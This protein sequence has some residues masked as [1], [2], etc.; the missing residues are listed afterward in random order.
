MKQE[1]IK[2]KEVSPPA[3]LDG[4]ADSADFKQ[5]AK[6]V[7][8]L[9]REATREEADIIFEGSP[10]YVASK[11]PYIHGFY[12]GEGNTLFLETN[13]ALDPKAKNDAS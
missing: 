5:G 8:F 6:E 13:P 1:F 3:I 4:A 11:Y 9:T 2:P 10:D 12:Y 7:P